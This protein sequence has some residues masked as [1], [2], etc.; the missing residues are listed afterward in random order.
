LAF[1][2]ILK[3]VLVALSNTAEPKYSNAQL[4]C[5]SPPQNLLLVVDGNHI[6]G[7]HIA[8][9]TQGFPLGAKFGQNVKKKKGIF[10]CNI[11]ISL[12]ENPKIF[13]EVFLENFSHI[14]TLILIL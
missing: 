4:D 6:A 12:E 9:Q 7:N 3:L 8:A 14:W 13:G 5:L 10:C 1:S 2:I 11:V